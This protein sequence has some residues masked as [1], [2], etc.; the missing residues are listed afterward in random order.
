MNLNRTLAST[1]LFPVSTYSIYMMD[2]G[3]PVGFRLS[4]KHPE[5]VQ[6]LIVQNGDAYDEGLDN[7]FWKP[8]MAYWTDRSKA[9]GDGL[10]SLLTLDAT[11]W[12]YTSGARELE[13]ISPDTFQE[14][15]HYDWPGNVRELQHALERACI[16]A[17]DGRLRFD[18]PTA[19]LRQQSK[20]EPSESPLVQR[21]MTDE[22]LRSLE[23]NNI[24]ASLVRCRGK[25]YGADGAAALLGLKPTTLNS[26]IKSLGIKEE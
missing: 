20:S 17:V 10:R 19:G 2:Y 5:R 13:T 26:R 23:A 21:I 11:K 6:S 16:V 9:K 24:R 1:V 4:V 3:A 8:I 22:E 25:V 14:L 15:Q 7:D 12:Q 18:F